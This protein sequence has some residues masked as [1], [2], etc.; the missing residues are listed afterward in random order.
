M[1]GASSEAAADL[2]SVRR[3][4]CDGIVCGGQC[5][6]SNIAP[7][8][9]NRVGKGIRG[10]LLGHPAYLAAGRVGGGGGG[11][12]YPEGPA[13]LPQAARPTIAIERLSE[14]SEVPVAKAAAPLVLITSLFHGGG[15]IP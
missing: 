10:H 5:V 13:L 7:C 12:A 15:H 9:H 11:A 4:G 3:G 1:G 8:K 2:D 6:P 14:A